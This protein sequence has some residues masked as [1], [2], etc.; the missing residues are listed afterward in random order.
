NF[1]GDSRFTDAVSKPFGPFLYD[2]LVGIATGSIQTEHPYA[3]NLVTPAPTQWPPWFVCAPPGS[4][5]S[6][7]YSAR[8]TARPGVE[9]AATSYPDIGCVKFVATATATFV[10]Q[11]PKLR[12]CPISWD[13]LSVAASAAGLGNLNLLKAVRE[14]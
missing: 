6:L 7:T 2:E 4:Q 11:E 3:H 13:A 8:F 14:R 10:P 5:G 1:A 9:V 12:S